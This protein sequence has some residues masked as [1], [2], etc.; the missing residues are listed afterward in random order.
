MSMTPRGC[1]RSMEIEPS[2]EQ[3]ARKNAHVKDLERR[4]LFGILHLGCVPSAN[5]AVLNVE[6]SESSFFAIGTEKNLA[7]FAEPQRL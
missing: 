6:A 5:G 4:M 3:Y 1:E 2:Q 7:D